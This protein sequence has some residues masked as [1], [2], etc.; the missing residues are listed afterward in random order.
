MFARFDPRL[1][2]AV[3][4]AAC[5]ARST[6]AEV[7]VE[8]SGALP[9]VPCSG[10]CP[11]GCHDDG[12]CVELVQIAVGAG[13]ACAVAGD[14]RVRCW[15]N[16][17]NGQLGDGT[18]DNALRPVLVSGLTRVLDIALG[19]DHSCARLVDRTVRCWGA[20]Y[21]GQLGD[22]TK[23]DRNTPVEVVG[24][25]GVTRIF[26]G[27]NHT[28][29]HV[30]DAL[31]CWGANMDGQLGD[32]TTKDRWTPV[33]VV[34]L[35][36]IVG[37]SAGLS[38]TCAVTDDGTLQCWGWNNS[39]QLGVD[40][41]TPSRAKPARVEGVTKV[42]EVGAGLGNTCVRLEDGTVACWGLDTDGELGDGTRVLFRSAPGPV[43][44]IHTATQLSAG[45]IHAC[46][47]LA[48]GTATCWGDD[49]NHTIG[50]VGGGDRLRPR[51]V[52]NIDAVDAIAAGR[53]STCAL[54]K[55]TRVDCWGLNDAGE[56]GDGTTTSRLEP[57]PVRW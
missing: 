30:G 4:V 21:L 37:G 19:S 40:P 3:F 47:R 16:N 36:K 55:P 5:G 10:A 7:R 18:T 26:L 2:L 1:L 20:N 39:G 56:I 50:H 35:P 8:D 17:A 29:A 12:R 43:S 34:G 33:D 28:C 51:K 41:S 48:D 9:S 52:S 15:G 46:V 11:L 57:T 14:G 32:G 49:Y 45:W 6:L 44:D 13:H 31:K 24:L 53:Y 25:T 27:G 38:H 22:G 54:R 42:K 23:T